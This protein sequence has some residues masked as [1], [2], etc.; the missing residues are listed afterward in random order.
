MTIRDCGQRF[1]FQESE[2]RHSIKCPYKGMGPKAPAMKVAL[3]S[4]KEATKLAKEQAEQALNQAQEKLNIKI[5]K[6]THSVN[7]YLVLFM[8]VRRKFTP[9]F[10]W[11]MPYIFFLQTSPQFKKETFYSL[12]I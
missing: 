12:K 3:L 6:S 10:D 11:L 1:M 7:N 2:R 8:I 4:L 9:L 5:E